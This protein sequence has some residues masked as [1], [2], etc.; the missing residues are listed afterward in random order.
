M[1]LCSHYNYPAFSFLF[2]NFL[3]PLVFWYQLGLLSC[4]RGTVLKIFF[5]LSNLSLVY[6]Y[7]KFFLPY[8]FFVSVFPNSFSVVISLMLCW[9]LFLVSDFLCSSIFIHLVD[10]VLLVYLIKWT[11][12]T[13]DPQ[14]AFF[15]L[16]EGEVK[17]QGYWLWVSCFVGVLFVLRSIKVER[18]KVRGNVEN[19]KCEMVADMWE[20]IEKRSFVREFHGRLRFL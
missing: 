12:F 1:S 10:I 19:R 17:W 7:P 6:L 9:F 13:E 18:K 20:R 16:N 8:F 3:H 11:S 4:L 14:W 15:I 2:V 5:L